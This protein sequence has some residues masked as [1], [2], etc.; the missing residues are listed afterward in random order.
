MPVKELAASLDQKTALLSYF[1][2]NSR[3][4]VWVV[5]KDSVTA[6]SV[7]ADADKLAALVSDYRQAIAGRQKDKTSE[8][9]SA[10]F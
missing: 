9:F 10:C 5:T 4:I 3:A 1:L 6:V 7:D 2:S 8:L